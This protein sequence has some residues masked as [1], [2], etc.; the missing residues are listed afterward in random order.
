M[1]CAGSPRMPADGAQ[2]AVLACAPA[3]PS[4]AGPQLVGTPLDLLVRATLAPRHWSAV[5][6]LGALRVAEGGISGAPAVASAAGDRLARLQPADLA[7]DGAAW[8]EVASLCILLARFEQAGRSRHASET[9]VQRLTSAQPSVQS[10]TDRQATAVP[11]CQ[12]WA[13]WAAMIFAR[14]ASRCSASRLAAD[15]SPRAHSGAEGCARA[16]GVAH[17]DRR[18]H[19]I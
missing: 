17:L 1:N 18:M 2:R 13:S 15:A 4:T 14:S 7:A 3:L 19:P 6:T 5:P 8:R 10:Y 9:I 11:A 16:R 12:G